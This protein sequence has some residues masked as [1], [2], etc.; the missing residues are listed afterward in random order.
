MG[1]IAAAAFAALVVAGP[2]VAGGPTLVLGAAEDGARQPTIVTAKTQLDLLALAGLRAIRV[3]SRWS[4]GLDEPVPE[5]Q[6]ALSVVSAA[7][8]LTG[9]RVIVSVYNTD[10]STTPLSNTDQTQFASYAAAIARKNVALR[11]FV[12]GNEPNLN[13]FWMP[14]FAPDGSNAAARA[15]ETLLARTYDALKAVSSRINVIGVAVSPRGNDKPDGIRPTH[16]PTTFITDLGDAYRKSGRELPIMDSFGIH[17]YQDNSSVPPSFTHPNNTTIAIADY[18]KLVSLLGKAFDG[19]AQPGSTLPIVYGEFGVETTIPAQK[20]SLYTGT[21]PASVKP[22]D[23]ATQGRF[24]R[25]ALAL[26]FCQP[27]VVTFLFFHAI[28]EPSLDRWQ[29]GVFY[30]DETAKSSLADVEVA[31]R[32]TRGGVIAKCAGLELTPNAVVAYPKGAS[33][34][35]IPLKVRITCDIDCAYRVRLERYPRRSTT[36]SVRG[37]ARAGVPATIKLPARRVAPGRYRFT[38]TL[39]APVNT[40]PAKQLASAPITLR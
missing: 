22:V 4:P 37:R 36:L 28:D 19:T 32:A 27:N 21:E 24:Y 11:E 5:E 23:A 17:P 39:T 6:S 9:M 25:Q 14:Q 2:A 31:T 3:T 30:V 35:A 38:V 7:A 16:S 29:S 12:I 8:N 18:D 15:Y 34:R 20:A 40:G 33:L 1:R 10:S 13:R 26:A